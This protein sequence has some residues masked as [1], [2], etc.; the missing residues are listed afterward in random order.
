MNTTHKKRVPLSRFR[1]I[2]NEEG[3][4]TRYVALRTGFAE[5]SLRQL[6]AGKGYDKFSEES[7]SKIASVLNRTK[8]EVFPE[9]APKPSLQNIPRVG[10]SLI[11]SRV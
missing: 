11:Q 9:K 10:V 4:I 8:E 7:L 1:E 2:L 5:S 3:L 6:A